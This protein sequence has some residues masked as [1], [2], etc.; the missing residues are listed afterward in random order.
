MLKVV[1]VI[2]VAC[3]GA[4]A[5]DASLVTR[6]K[7]GANSLLVLAGCLKAVGVAAGCNTPVAEHDGDAY[8][9]RSL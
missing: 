5:G 1:D 9:F 3:T 2:G 6:T 7:D 4:Y 8:V